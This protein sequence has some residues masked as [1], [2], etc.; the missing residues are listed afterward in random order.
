[1]N[2]LTWQPEDA[3][4]LLSL[5]EAAGIDALVFAR[6]NTVSVA[7]LKELEQGEGNSFYNPQIK[8]STGLKLLKKLGHEVVMLCEVSKSEEQTSPVN[9]DDATPEPSPT[10]AN[11]WATS[12]PSLQAA[13][14]NRSL[15]FSPKPLWVAFSVLAFG[16]VVLMGHEWI[17]SNANKAVPSP[18]APERAMALAT[19]LPSTPE[20]SAPAAQAVLTQSQPSALSALSTPSTD[21]MA[22]PTQAP[23]CDPKMREGS[24]THTTAAPLKPGN[25]VFFE[26]IEDTE[27]CVRDQDN[28]LTLVKLPAGMKKTVRGTAPFLVQTGQWDKLKMFFQG[29]RVPINANAPAHLVLNNQDF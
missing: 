10:Q 4:L 24:A 26:A 5:R 11:T 3:Q 22:T 13:P 12:E 19:M 25:Y 14:L 18:S 2:K 7:Q 6:M 1:M 23:A 8:R 17:Q 21:A 28:L 16:A 27:L 15:G 9:M 20:A 29:R